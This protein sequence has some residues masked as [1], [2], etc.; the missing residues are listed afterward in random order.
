MAEEAI[1]RLDDAVRA[2]L[3]ECGDEDTVSGWVIGYQTSRITADPRFL[4]L[5]TA[6]DYTLSP[7]TTGE[8]ALGLLTLTKSRLERAMLSYD[9][10]D[11]DDDRD[12]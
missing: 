11:D 6:T 3:L 7:S 4:P 9:D 12:D 10:V 2:F 8:T 1:D 5:T